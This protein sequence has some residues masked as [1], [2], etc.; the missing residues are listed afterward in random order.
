MI[1]RFDT[2]K[3]A[4]V[5]DEEIATKIFAKNLNIKNINTQCFKSGQ[6]FLNYLEGE[7]IDLV[8]LDILMPN[9][10]GLETLQKIRESYSSFE[11]PV[12]MLTAKDQATDIVEALKL[13]ANDY[14][15]KPANPDVAFAR[16]RT[17]LELRSFYMDSLKKKELETLN[18]MIITYNHEINNPLTIALG[19]L[20]DDISQ[21]DNKKLNKSK[22]AMYRIADI[23]K[24][25]QKLTDHNVEYQDYAGSKSKM[26]KLK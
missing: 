3:I 15:T 7:K 1:E 8:L 5:D 18:S 16:I 2:L 6:E 23:V 11:L 19:N 17:Q 20:K 4:V 24:S 10:S 22:E 13:G 26:I 9:L 12:I 14:I 21:M 25:I